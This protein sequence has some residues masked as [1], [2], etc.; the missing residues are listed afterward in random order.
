MFVCT[1]GWLD[2]SDV[3]DSNLDVWLN[4]LCTLWMHLVFLETRYQFVLLLDIKQI[5]YLRRQGNMLVLRCSSIDAYPTLQQAMLK[6]RS[7]VVMS[8]VDL[9]SLNCVPTNPGKNKMSLVFTQRYESIA[10]RVECSKH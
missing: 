7:F 8:W 9:V 5:R 3:T 2:V 10:K 1:S 6:G 4:Y